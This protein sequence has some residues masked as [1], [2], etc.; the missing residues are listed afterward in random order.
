MGFE[1]IERKAQ[2]LVGKPFQPLSKAVPADAASMEYTAYQAIRF[3]KEKAI[4]QG[5][6]LPF[7]LEMFYRAF[8]FPE[9]I[10]INVIS[11]DGV[12]SEVPFFHGSLH[13]SVGIRQAAGGSGG[14]WLRRAE[15][16]LPIP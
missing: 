8:L 14:L 7:R 5:S 12:T 6:R 9:R 1:D 3:N 11:P 15:G 16:L 2:D 10:K 4:W 13:H